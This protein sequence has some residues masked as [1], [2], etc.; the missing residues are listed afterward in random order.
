MGFAAERSISFANMLKDKGYV[1]HFID[2][3]LSTVEA[4]SVLHFTGKK[5]KESKKII[6]SVSA[7]IIL[8]TYLRGINNERIDNGS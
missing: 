6:D 4:M 1:I 3:R 2:E 5:E 8:E 7:N